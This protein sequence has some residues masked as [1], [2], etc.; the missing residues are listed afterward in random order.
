ME[1]HFDI[2][3]LSKIP[4]RRDP[5]ITNEPL[6]WRYFVEPLPTRLADSQLDEREYMV[7]C[8]FRINTQYKGCYV[9]SS[10]RNMGV[11]RPCYP[12]DVGRFYRWKTTRAT[13]SR[14]TAAIP[15]TRP[16]GGRAPTLRP[17]GLLGVHNGEISSY[18]REP[19]FYRDAQATMHASD[20]TRGPY[21]FHRLSQPQTGADHG[22]CL[23][24][25]A[26]PFWQTIASRPRTSGAA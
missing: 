23:E 17:A 15:P 4:T 3:N 1:K 16:A 13:A 5:N 19:P 21:L 2:I 8:V 18:G 6:I 12:E 9:F 14:P 25:I 20:G 7:K 22:G 11:F 26:A 10:G 24:I